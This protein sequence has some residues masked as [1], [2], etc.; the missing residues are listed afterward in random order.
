MSNK[1]HILENMN[2]LTITRYWYRVSQYYQFNM[3]WAFREISTAISETKNSV[4]SLL[5]NNLLPIV[6][7][8][9]K[10]LIVVVVNILGSLSNNS[11]LLVGNST[12]EMNGVGNGKCY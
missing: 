1:L 5:S 3:V 9:Q 7:W 11:T 8:I 12:C 4:E 10:Q 2:F 6:T